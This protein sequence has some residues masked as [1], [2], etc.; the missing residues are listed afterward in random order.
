MC[1]SLPRATTSISDSRNTSEHMRLLLPNAPYCQLKYLFPLLP[2]FAQH[3][4]A[5]SRENPQSL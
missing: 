5:V 2:A 4:V 1:P 3:G